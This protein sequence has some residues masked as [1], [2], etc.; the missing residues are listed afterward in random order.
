M[1]I[2]APLKLFHECKGTTVT[3]E[4]KTGE[5]YRGKMVETEDNMNC[6]LKDVTVTGKDGKQS[7]IEYI[8]IRGSQ[9]RFIIA[10]EMFKNSP[11]LKPIEQRKKT[12]QTK[13]PKMSKASK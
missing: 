3:I 5:M 2:G 8:F 4:T 11:C 1:N 10:P 7:K 9:I 12:Q 6:Q 13:K